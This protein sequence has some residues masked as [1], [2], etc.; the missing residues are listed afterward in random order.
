MELTI[1]QALQQGVAAHKAGKL[2]DAEKLYLAIL[3]SQPKHPDANHNLGVLAVGVG[4]LQEALPLF[5]LALETNPKQG[6]FWL[7]Y[8]DAL[9]KLDQLDDARK[10]LQ[11][12]K[13]FGL[14]GD[15]VDQLEVQLNGKIGSIPTPI[16]HIGNPSKQQVDGL[17]ALYTQGK[18][19]EAVVQGTTLASQFP[20]D[21]T[22]PNILGAIYSGLSRYEEAITSYKKAIELKPEYAEAHSNLG[23]A[24]NKLRQHEEAVRS[25]DKAIELKPNYIQAYNNLGNVL[26]ELGKNEEAIKSFNKAIE[27]NPNYAEAHSN[28][29]IALS[30]LAKYEEAITSYNRA[31]ELKP[32]DAEAH[33]NIGNVLNILG[34][35]EEA[36]TIYNKAIELKPDFAEA[37]SNLGVALNECGR[38]EIAI[39]SYKKA[40]ELR[41]GYSEAHNNLGNALN[42]LGYLEEAV[43]SYNKAIELRPE[44]TKAHINLGNALNELGYLEEAITSYNRAIELKPDFVE[45]YY[46]LGV[47]LSTIK[48][49][50][51]SA[52]LA[53]NF[54]DILTFGTVIRPKSIAGSIIILLKHHDTIKEVIGCNAQNILKDVASEFCIRLSKIPLFLK[55]M[56]ICPIPDLE[57]EEVLIELRRILLLERKKLSGND[58]L[59]IFQRALALQCFTNEFIYE[60][61]KKEKV[62]IQSLEKSLQKSFSNN[63]ELPSYDIA[64]LASYRSLFNYPWARGM[65]P[66]SALEVLFKRQVIEVNQEVELKK[67][68]PRLNPINDD[69]SLAVQTQY[70]ENPYPRWINTRLEMKPMSIDELIAKLELKVTNRVA[71]A[72]EGPKILV[73]GCGTGQHALSTASRFKNSHVTAI[74]LSLSSLAYAKRKTEELG[75]TNIDY[76]Q[77]DILD[78]K[79]LDKQFDV[80]ESVGSLH[81][82]AEPLAG[83]KV[84]T[85]CLKPGGIMRIG[86]YSELARQDIVK[87][88]D[89]IAKNKIS[90]NTE[91]M[92]KFRRKISKL[93]DVKFNII[94][95]DNDFYS[96]STLRDL[97]F[98]VQEHRFTIPQISA[99]LDELGLAFMGF[100]FLDRRKK[101]PYKTTNPGDGA[102]YDLDKWHEYETQ[103]PS[104]L[105]GYSFWVQKL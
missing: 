48:P 52:T 15:Q 20:N 54:L 64:C 44:D 66:R 40:I 81:H 56:E 100:E 31:I 34:D 71:L 35:Y 42:E 62:A 82:M 75:V 7:S 83:W 41:P 37:Y 88:R 43:T 8:I 24:L 18:L 46:N 84:L 87:V 58:D 102:I 79:M 76:L 1:D 23:V 16:V 69:I 6:Q 90:A 98:H 39:I 92:T 19:Q 32:D 36:I 3:S 45:T 63:E 105:A 99:A 93:D 74:D 67:S 86:L 29:G 33:H 97:L 91:Q 60:E 2:Q 96:T 4:K 9:I 89:M 73:A 77:A 103:N 68:I 13:T 53:K 38:N 22:I 10:I 94:K 21:P 30:D 51:F 104:F 59:I 47:A 27:L 17:I 95:K 5:K 28:L 14:K 50:D 49:P 70:E 65:A 80:V 55:I 101:E 26:N 72:P 61:T 25:Y 11:Q 57:I 85:H 78:L 12:G